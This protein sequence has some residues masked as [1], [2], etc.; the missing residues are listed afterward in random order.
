MKSHV[1]FPKRPVFAPFGNKYPENQWPAMA[2]Q[3]NSVLPP[4]IVSFDGF[5]RLKGENVLI[6]PL[7]R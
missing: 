4:R 7:V 3:E 2:G 6:R 1:D 5:E